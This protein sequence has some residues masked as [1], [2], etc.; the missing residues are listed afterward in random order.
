MEQVADKVMMTPIRG[1]IPVDN[2]A[3]R[4]PRI[5]AANVNIQNIDVTKKLIF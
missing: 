3:P 4:K 1:I 2:G 5:D